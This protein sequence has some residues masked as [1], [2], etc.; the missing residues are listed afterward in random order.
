MFRCSSSP[1]GLTGSPDRGKTLLGGLH[2]L[3]FLTFCVSRTIP[4]RFVE[5]GELW[6]GRD[7]TPEEAVAAVEQTSFF[8][9]IAQR[10]FEEANP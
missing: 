5:E 10:L 6:R 4:R 3:G 7:E 1:D 8:V 9:I 2:K